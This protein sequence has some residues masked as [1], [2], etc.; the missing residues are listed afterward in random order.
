MSITYQLPFI[1]SSSVIDGATNKSPDGSSFSVS[2]DR[3]ILVPKEAKYCYIETQASEIW[4]VVPN[5]LTGKNDLMKLTWDNVGLPTIVNIIIPQG[6]YDV[7]SLNDTVNRLLVEA[8]TPTDLIEITGNDPTQKVI[9]TTKFA[10]TSIDFTISQSFRELLGFDSQ[11]LGPSI[12]AETFISDNVASFNNIDYFLIHCDIINK[13]LRNNNRYTQI[14]SQ[15]L[16]D[17]PPGSQIL[18]RPFNIPKIP[19]NEL[20][21]DKRNLINIW[22]TDHNNNRVNTTGEDFSVRLVINYII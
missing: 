12:A 14:I 18:S 11:V 20:I 10:G 21:G 4:N 9:I 13:G 8:G 2:F 6:L 7:T 17:V 15:V 3:P 19:A 22:L 5:I 1:F 16:I